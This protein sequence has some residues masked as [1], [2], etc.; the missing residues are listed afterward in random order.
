MLTDK[1]RK[2]LKNLRDS[3]VE[4]RAAREANDDAISE[5]LT[6]EDRVRKASFSYD[7]KLYLV[8]RNMDTGT[9]KFKKIIE[10]YGAHKYE[11]RIEFLTKALEEAN[12]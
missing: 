6:A 9:F 3:D 1:E 7:H 12:D 10:K 2:I 11:E 5:A 4:Y 8:R